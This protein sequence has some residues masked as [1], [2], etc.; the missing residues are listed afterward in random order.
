MMSNL[1]NNSQ[2]MVANVDMFLYW[3]D[4]GKSQIGWFT[5]IHEIDPTIEWLDP[6]VNVK[7]QATIF[8]L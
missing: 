8:Y 6:M 4:G 2:I 3:L 5:V 7:I 1:S